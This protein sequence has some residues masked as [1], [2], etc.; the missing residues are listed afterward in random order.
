MT[1][2][3]L[4]ARGLKCPLPVLKARKR[5]AAMRVGEVLTVLADDPVAPLDLEHLAQEDGHALVEMTQTETHTIAR[6]QKGGA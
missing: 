1:D 5:L 3:F 2:Q 4:D 6:L